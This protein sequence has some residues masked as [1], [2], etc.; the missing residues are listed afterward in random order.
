[1]LSAAVYVTKIPIASFTWGNKV[2]EEKG[3]DFSGQTTYK[4]VPGSQIQQGRRENKTSQTKIRRTR[5][6]Y[7]GARSRRHTIPLVS[8][9]S[10]F[11]HKL[12]F[13]LQLK[14]KTR[15]SFQS[16]EVCEV[17][18]DKFSIYTTRNNSSEKKVLIII[19]I[20]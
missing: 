10:V 14:S 5:C 4:P 11:P 6:Y 15:Q 2:Q 19:N 7:L 16:C 3:W 12:I 1:M 9:P 13:S 17:K 20:A 18:L 8:R